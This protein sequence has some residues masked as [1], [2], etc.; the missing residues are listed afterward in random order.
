MKNYSIGLEGLLSSCQSVGDALAKS[1][2]QIRYDY[3]FL[4]HLQ[5]NLHD[6]LSDKDFL[7]GLELAAS[8]FANDYKLNYEPST[9]SR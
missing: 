8:N 7:S 6:D 3:V 2:V 4:E 9:T 1:G 5:Y